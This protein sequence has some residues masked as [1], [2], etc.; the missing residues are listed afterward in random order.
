MEQPDIV[1]TCNSGQK[2]WYACINIK[3]SFLLTFSLV[4]S[5][6]CSTIDD[7][8]DVTG[9]KEFIYLASFCQ[10]QVI[11]IN[12]CKAKIRI[13]RRN[14]AQAAAELSVTPGYKDVFHACQSIKL[15]SAS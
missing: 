8:I 4:N 15:Y 3:G 11:V 12:K 10:I 2:P 1:Y 7:I 13:G 9:A 5:R 14:L 6:K